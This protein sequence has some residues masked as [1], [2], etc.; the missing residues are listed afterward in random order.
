M[1]LLKRSALGRPEVKVKSKLISENLFGITGI[2]RAK[3]VL[4]YV[5]VKNEVDTKYIF[6]HFQKIKSNIFLP[7]YSKTNKNWGISRF[8]GF[9]NLTNGPF[10]TLQHEKTVVVA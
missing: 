9:D 10:N 8:L 7:T 4:L 2:T 3:N 5:P 6:A 1:L